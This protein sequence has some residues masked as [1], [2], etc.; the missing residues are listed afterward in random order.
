MSS[1]LEGD[2][3]LALRKLR[4]HLT[5]WRVLAIAAFALAIFMTVRGE[6]GGLASGPH[7]AAV[8]VEGIILKDP[9]MLEMLEEIANDPDV[10]ALIVNISSPGG[11]F[12]GG[13][14]YFKAL[15]KISDTK[16]VVAIMGDMATSGA[17]MTA[18]AA[19]RIYASRGTVTGS[20]GVIM[21]SANITGLLDKLGIAPEIIKSGPSK[22]VPN[23]MEDLTPN[24]RAQLQGIIDELQTMFLL[25]VSDRRSKSVDELRTIIGDGRI[26]T[27]T[28]AAKAGL[29]DEVG[30]ENDAR[31]WLQ[32]TH[33]VSTDLPVIEWVIEDPIAWWRE[34]GASMS[35]AIFGKSLLS[36]RLRLDG[37]LALWHP[38]LDE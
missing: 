15:R 22:A 27:G 20:I 7:V 1:G 2:T 18:I 8:E 5:V 38:S 17:Y 37:I 14:A 23:P 33:E 9:D 28:T 29:I 26:M 32:S 4:R 25:M 12:G 16:P 24:S 35:T 3:I 13:E 21:Q 19:D 31:F 6:T 10:E 36:E 11:T 34:A 30:D